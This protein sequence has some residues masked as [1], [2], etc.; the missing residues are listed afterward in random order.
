M[1]ICKCNQEKHMKWVQGKNGHKFAHFLMKD[2]T[3]PFRQWCLTWFDGWQHTRYVEV[4]VLKTQK[5]SS[6]NPRCSSPSLPMMLW[7]LVLSV[8]LV[9]SWPPAFLL[10][11][12]LVRPVLSLSV[13]LP[14][15][16]EDQSRFKH[17]VESPFHYCRDLDWRWR[18]EKMSYFM[19][20]KTMEFLYILY[21]ILP[22]KK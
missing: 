11:L 4:T 1:K 21:V 16:K 19:K 10:W 3:Q 6:Y 9:S 2:M 5:T 20:L 22:S 13:Q 8:H 15:K 17:T 14:I 12:W 18:G 7:A